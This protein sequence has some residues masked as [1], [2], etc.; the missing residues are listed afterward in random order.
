[1]STACVDFHYVQRLAICLPGTWDDTLSAALPIRQN[2]KST[3]SKRFQKGSVSKVGK[4]WYG[5]YWRDVPGQEKREHPVVV[6]GERKTVTK[7]EA[8]KMLEAIIE[9]EGLNSKTYLSTLPAVTFN[10]IADAWELKYLPQLAL[11]T[12]DDAP[13]LIAKHM[14]PFFGKMPIDSIK[15]GTVNEWIT[16]LLKSGLH[17]KTV[18]N[19][20]KDF[21]AI[22]N[23][24]SKQNDVPKRTWYPS[25]P[26][27]PD[28][29]QRWY[30]E[31]EALQIIEVSA[32][33]PGRGVLLGQ[34]KPLF[35]LVAYSGLR[36][37]EI[38][39]LHVED[40]DAGVIHVQ[41]SVFEGV[42]V[43]TKG[44]RRRFVNIDSSTA[45]M[46]QEHLGD[47]TT[48]RVF[49][50]MNGTP[51]NNCQLVTVLHWA[52]KQL[53]IRPGGMH[54][55]RH[56]RISKLQADN[57]PADLIRRQVGH[58]SLRTTSGYTHFTEE[59]IRGIVERSAL[60]CTGKP[61][62]YAN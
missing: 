40:I 61:I 10:D 43:E 7:L 52:A 8:R 15:T 51:V 16:G 37:G 47:R 6:L 21:R 27:I 50:G 59:Y 11:S 31:A 26:N 14:R 54:A 17:P 44:K 39:G 29:E 19:R 13:M 46:L 53:G 32:Q 57:V 49:E 56:G 35:R 28:I 45:Q 9:K 5:R 33:Y 25:L 1:M 34:Y 62:L 3:M 60:S 23:W 20:W 41:C 55:F 4:M 18:Q 12:Q 2:R 58:C 38:S 22:M 48:G 36:S 30:T 24:H 42:E